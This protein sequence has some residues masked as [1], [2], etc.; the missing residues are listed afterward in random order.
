MVFHCIA[1]HLKPPDVLDE[2]WKHV[3]E[4]AAL[5]KV[6]GAGGK[7]PEDG[8]G[9]VHHEDVLGGEEDAQGLPRQV[10]EG[11]EIISENES[12]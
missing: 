3:G 2:R 1:S 12:L 9:A 6:P 11:Q 7:D 5:D 10:D 4:G 8:E